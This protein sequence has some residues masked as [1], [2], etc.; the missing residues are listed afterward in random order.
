MSCLFKEMCHALVPFTARCF[1]G[2][3]LDRW[4][5]V[6]GQRCEISYTQVNLLFEW[7][8]SQ[9]NKELSIK[10]KKNKTVESSKKWNGNVFV[11]TQDL[12]FG[13]DLVKPGH[14]IKSRGSSAAM[15]INIWWLDRQR[16]Q[17]GCR[18]QRSVAAHSATF[19][20]SVWLVAGTHTS[21]GLASIS[22]RDAVRARMYSLEWVAPW[23]PLP[24]RHLR[25]A[26]NVFAPYTHVT[27]KPKTCKQEGK[28]SRMFYNC[29][30]TLVVTIS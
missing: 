7:H 1:S 19:P 27:R 28:G 18:D 20:Q 23:L 2:G 26:K 6:S 15:H 8:L 13:D 24:R 3:S 14:K 11:A 12:C 25:I 17:R 22:P 5:D 30:E 29:A 21:S 10:N 9:W 4:S 16:A